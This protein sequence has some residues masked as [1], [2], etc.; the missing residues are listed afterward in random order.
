MKKVFLRNVVIAMAGVG[1][2]AG[3]AMA[4]PVLGSGYQWNNSDYWT[5]TDL[6][7]GGNSDGNSI[8]QLRLELASYESSFGLYTLDKTDPTKM[9]TT[10]QIFD[11]NDEPSSNSANPTEASAF[12]RKT[13]TGWQVSLTDS[14]NDSDWTDFSD[15]FGFYFDVYT[16]G[17]TDTTA[18][19]RWTTDTQFNQYANGTPVDTD[20]E[21]VLVAYNADLDT[22]N[23]YL[24]DQISTNSDRDFDDMVVGADDLAPVPEPATM[25]LFGTGLLG[26][27][28]VA[29]KKK[30]Q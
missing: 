7:T 26:L 23:I 1:L 27:A 30:N 4:L 10:F 20:I 18:D 11:K 15:V 17:S 13:T 6:T 8:F 24:D 3:S 5:L 2:T 21:H 25:L 29:R 19:Y 22:A 16:D 28:G 12:F 9:G 14:A